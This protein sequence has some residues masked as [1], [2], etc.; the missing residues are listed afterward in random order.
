M[1]ILSNLSLD[2]ELALQNLNDIIL[3]A[4][5]AKKSLHTYVVA[6]SALKEYIKSEEIIYPFPKSEIPEDSSFENWESYTFPTYISIKKARAASGLGTKIQVIHGEVD[7]ET[8]KLDEDTVSVSEAIAL[9]ECYSE[10]FRN[11][12]LQAIW[13][14]VEAL[15]LQ[16]D[17]VNE[18]FFH[19]EERAPIYNP[20]SQIVT[21]LISDLTVK[22]REL[23]DL[24][25]G[26]LFK[27]SEVNDLKVFM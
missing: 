26:V 15:A 22:L 27:S 19:V 4:I 7:P 9:D 25:D 6:T 8:K 12:C 3:D 1:K 24:V 18:I 5:A 2:T 20:I 21:K 14:P 17:H 16:L 10:E 23:N 13:L 11:V